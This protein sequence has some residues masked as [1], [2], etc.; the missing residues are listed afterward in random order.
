MQQGEASLN[1][2]VKKTPVQDVHAPPIVAIL[3]DD[4]GEERRPH[5]DIRFKTSPSSALYSLVQLQASHNNLRRLS[6]RSK[7]GQARIAHLLDAR[8]KGDAAAI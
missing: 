2:Q 6:R 8:A 1:G 7:R 4:I 3:P 5:L